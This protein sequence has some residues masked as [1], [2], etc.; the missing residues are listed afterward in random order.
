VK[1]PEDAKAEQGHWNDQNGA[2]RK[3]HQKQD[4]PASEEESECHRHHGRA[5][6][7]VRV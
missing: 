1:R 2:L 7:A 5:E 3:D 6:L 4:E